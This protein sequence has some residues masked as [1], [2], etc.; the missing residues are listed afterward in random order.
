MVLSTTILTFITLLIGSLHAKKV[1]IRTEHISGKS[2]E[3]CHLSDLH[4]GVFYGEKHV[5]KIVNI[6]KE[7]DPDIVCI[8]G[9]IFD[10]SGDPQDI[11][12]QPFKELDNVYATL[13][14]HD[15]YFGADKTQTMLENAGITVL[16]NEKAVVKGY[17]VYGYDDIHIAGK[18]PDN[19]MSVQQPSI[20]LYHRPGPKEFLRNTK[21]DI[22]LCGHTHAGQVLPA[23]LAILLTDTYLSGFFSVGKTYVNICQGTGTGGPPIRIGTSSEITTISIS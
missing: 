23:G 22:F 21:A 3:I 13:G 9:D 15:G 18:H 11:W 17:T 6:V 14:N 5:R 19:K 20:F 4:L 2:L 7:Q 8:T 12:L 16:R 10:G 1:Y